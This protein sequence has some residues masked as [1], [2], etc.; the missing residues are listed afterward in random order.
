MYMTEEQLIDFGFEKVTISH[1][2]SDNGYDYY[3]YQKELCS[4]V[5]LHSTDSVDVKDNY[6]VLKSFD[7]PALEIRNPEH[8]LQFLEIMNN[9]TC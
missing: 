8:Y 3:Y 1:A 7:I 2:E 9:I 6:W 5:E 4:G